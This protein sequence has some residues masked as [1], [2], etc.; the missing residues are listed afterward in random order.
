MHKQVNI[1]FILKNGIMK[2][3]LMIGHLVMPNKTGGLKNNKMNLEKP[4]KKTV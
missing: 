2:T 4:F 1:A 3:G